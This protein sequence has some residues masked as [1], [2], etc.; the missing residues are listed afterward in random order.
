MKQKKITNW[1]LQPEITKKSFTRFA[2]SDNCT[3][4]K[5]I[6]KINK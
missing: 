1:Y 6:T 2:M 3:P 4:K 5:T